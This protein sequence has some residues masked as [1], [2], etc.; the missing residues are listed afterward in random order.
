[1]AMTKTEKTELALVKEG[2]LW[3]RKKLTAR[4]GKAA[5]FDMSSFAQGTCS[6]D[7]NMKPI[8][9]GSTH[10]IGGWLDLWMLEQ[11]PD[12]YDIEPHSTY[13]FLPSD[14]TDKFKVGYTT[15][16]RMKKLF[17]PNIN[18]IDVHYHKLSKKQAVQAIDNF[19]AG[20]RNPWVGVVRPNQ[21]VK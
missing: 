21:L 7:E 3:V 15:R 14:P 10:C 16:V 18:N 9:C 12:R 6:L 1:M 5:A 17:Y 19:I 20:K 8:D 4:G 11:K 13:I 2:L